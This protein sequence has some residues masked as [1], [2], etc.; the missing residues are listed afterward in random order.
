VPWISAPAARGFAAVDVGLPH[1]AFADQKRRD[2]D[3]RKPCE[4]G[5][6]KDA[7]FADHQAIGRDQRRQRL[8]GR[9]RGLEGAKIAVIDADHRRAKFEGTIQ[10][11]ALMNF[12]QDIHAVRNRGVLD[13]FGGA[14]VERCH[15]DQDAVGAMGTGLEPPGR[16]RT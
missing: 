2:P 3:T 13:V 9:K 8:A 4:I 6:L 11:R 16:Y 10:L 5:R 12:D 7:A 14:V 15:D 1:Q